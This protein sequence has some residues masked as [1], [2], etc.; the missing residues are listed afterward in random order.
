[1]HFDLTGRKF[2]RW[3]VVRRNDVQGHHPLWLCVCERGHEKNVSSTNLRSGASTSCGCFR[4]EQIGARNQTHGLAPRGDAHPL[5]SI[6]C[7][8]HK[9]CQNRN[10]ANFRYYGGRG[11]RVCGRWSG[12]LGFANFVADMG[13]RPSLDHQIDRIDNNGNYEPDNCRWATRVEQVQ[14]R[15][16]WGSCHA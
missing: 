11:I 16:K 14:N 12:D 7:G 5:F 3:A 9:R 2:G 10:A 4:G 8:I 13:D 6:W 15:R 1:M